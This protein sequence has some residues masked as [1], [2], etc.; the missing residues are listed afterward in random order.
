MKLFLLAA[1]D[2]S[3]VGHCLQQAGFVCEVVV[4]AQ[5]LP[6]HDERNG[7]LVVFC[8][9]LDELLECHHPAM[10]AIFFAQQDLDVT[11]ML[12]ALHNGAV[13]CWSAAMSIEELAARGEAL[14]ARLQR[15]YRATQRVAQ[16]GE[17]AVR[18]SHL[19]QELQEDQKAG[20]SIQLGMLPAQHKRMGGFCFS[21]WVQPSLMLSGDFVDYFPLQ[22]RYLACFLADVAGHGASSALLTVMLKNIS[23]RLQQKFGRPRFESPGDMLAWINETLIGQGIEKHVAMFLGIIDKEAQ[24]LH[25]SMAAQ[26]PPALLCHSSGESVFLRQE[27]KPLGLFPGATFVADNVDFP[28]GST[29]LVFSDGVLDCLAPT[30]LAEKEAAL[31]TLAEALPQPVK[32][33][34]RLCESLKNLDDVSL[35]AVQHDRSA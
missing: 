35:L 6:V 19:E 15:T 13:D 34:S 16:D 28:A 22:D 33:W 30:D 20:Q 23:W 2:T 7:L 11:L 27:A 8:S 21:R 24:T 32:L 26:Y 3:S 29:L 25:Y 1:A 18:L 9:N 4:S 5:Q 17:A 14:M 10:V 31:Q 12:Q